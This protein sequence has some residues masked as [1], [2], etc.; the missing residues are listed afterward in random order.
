L[1]GQAVKVGA[2]FTIT[3]T[4]PLAGVLQNGASPYETLTRL[5]VEFDV[6][7]EV[8][9]F[10]LPPLLKLSVISGPPFML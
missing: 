8:V 2:W 9:I 7:G 10:K 4:L 5:K 3:V 1:E 6:S